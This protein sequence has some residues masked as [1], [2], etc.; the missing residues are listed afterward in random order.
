MNKVIWPERISLKYW[1]ACLVSDFK[2]ETLPILL[3]EN[4]FEKWATI[5]AGS[6]IFR[7]AA[8]PPPT[9]ITSGPAGE[10][11]I[12]WAKIVYTIMADEYNI[13]KQL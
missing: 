2:N 10:K 7:R 1:A 6:G 4:D 13:T 5:V 9:F 11:W 8:I 3:D 12:K